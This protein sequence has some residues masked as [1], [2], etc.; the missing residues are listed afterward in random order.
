MLVTFGFVSMVSVGHFEEQG[1]INKRCRWRIVHLA[2]HRDSCS[3]ISFL[4]VIV[5]PLIVKQ[6]EF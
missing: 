5:S 6:I 1:I 4:I 2:E 3:F